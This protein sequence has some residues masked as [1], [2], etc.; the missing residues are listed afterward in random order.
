LFKSSDVGGLAMTSYIVP[1]PLN[2]RNA[3]LETISLTACPQHT[4]RLYRDSPRLI[5]P[6]A[7]DAQCNTGMHSPRPL[8][9]P[10]APALQS[11]RTPQKTVVA[12]RDLSGAG[13]NRRSQGAMGP[14][15]GA[16][17]ARQR[18]LMD[19]IRHLSDR[20]G[21]ASGSLLDNWTPVGATVEP[22]SLMGDEVRA[23]PLASP[24]DMIST[25]CPAAGNAGSP[26]SFAPEVCRP[27]PADEAVPDLLRLI[28]T[29]E[30][31]S[32]VLEHKNVRLEA[33]NKCLEEALSEL[34]VRVNGLEKIL[35]LGAEKKK[36]QRHRKPQ[37]SKQQQQQRTRCLMRQ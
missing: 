1:S 16:I 23:A 17:A 15:L 20:L 2:C 30:D 33:R 10:A 24:R 31:Q 22:P 28:S 12:A 8:L 4:V 29:L 18:E 25:S 13:A 9:P 6:S 19:T 21:E 36:R 32:E 7:P 11:P 26:E 5:L 34:F 35:E 27:V 37:Q 14:S 3:S